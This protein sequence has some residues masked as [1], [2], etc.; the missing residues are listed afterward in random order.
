[1]P[2]NKDCYSCIYLKS[3]FT[4]KENKVNKNIDK[5]EHP[6]HVHIIEDKDKG[7]DDYIAIKLRK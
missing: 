7:C 4:L 1:M 6:E 5:C 3:E 2:I